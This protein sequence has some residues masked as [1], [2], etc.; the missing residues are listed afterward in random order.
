ML[1]YTKCDAIMIGRGL[2]GNPWLIKEID[3][4]LKKGIII[5]KPTYEE[6]IK[7]CQKHLDNLLKIKSEHVAVLEMRNHISWYIKGIPNHKEIQ[8]QCF[9]AKTKEE[10]TEI[11]DNYFKKLYN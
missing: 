10:I 8:N 7:M 1:E 2:Q 9:K 11:L 4:Y 6:R 5:E 3:T